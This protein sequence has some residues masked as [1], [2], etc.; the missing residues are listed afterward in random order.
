[1]SNGAGLVTVYKICPTLYEESYASVLIVLRK[2]FL[3]RVE[4]VFDT[5]VSSSMLPE[6]HER[7]KLQSVYCPVLANLSD[8]QTICLY[9]LLNFLIIC[10][11][12]MH[13]EDEKTSSNIL[14]I[15]KKM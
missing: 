1:M 3:K 7:P 5:F 13:Y 14:P 9:I 15:I 2:C 10:L 4:A 6:F 11:L 8:Y 12:C